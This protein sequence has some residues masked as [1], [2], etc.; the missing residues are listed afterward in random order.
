MQKIK[1]TVSWLTNGIAQTT[2]N[3]NKTLYTK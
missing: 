2:D 1:K 3:E